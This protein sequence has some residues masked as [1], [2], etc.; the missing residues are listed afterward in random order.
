MRRR[1]RTNHRHGVL[2]FCGKRTSHVQ[3]HGRVVDLAQRLWIAV[4]R[5]RQH[6]ATE[7]LNPSQFCGQVHVA[8]PFGDRLRRVVTDAAHAK[9]FAAGGGENLRGLAEVF[10]Q[11]PHADR[12]NTFD[13]IQR[14]QRFTGVHAAEILDLRA[15][16]QAPALGRW[17]TVLGSRSRLQSRP[18]IILLLPRWRT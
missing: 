4:V 7:F 18:E 11:L 12:A 10:E 16:L 2:V 13:E 17:V 14:N 15:H 3:H 8:F 5:L 9:Q 1:A 6:M